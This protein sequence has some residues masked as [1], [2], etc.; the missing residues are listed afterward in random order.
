MTEKIDNALNESRILVLVT[1]VLLG[2]QY[3][4]IFQNGFEK[5]PRASQY[6]K[7]SG[8]GLMLIA[9]ALLLSPA[10]YHRIVEQGN[11]SLKFHKFISQVS[12]QALLPFAIGLSFDFYIVAD[13]LLGHTTGLLFG[14]V[15]LG[16]A[17]F[18][19]YG[20]EVLV[21]NRDPK[22]KDKPC[23]MKSQ[24][25]PLKD[26]IKFVLMEARVVLPGTQALLG[27]QFAA[28]LTESFDKLART[29]QHIHLASLDAVGLSTVCL[30]APAA[31]HRI[32]EQGEDTERLHTFSSYMVLGAMAFLALGIAGDVFVV[33]QKVLHTTSV[34]WLWSSLLWLF[35]M[36]DGLALCSFAKPGKRV[37][38]HDPYRLLDLNVQ[39]HLSQK[40]A[41]PMKLVSLSE[42]ET[43][44][45]GDGRP[46]CHR[47]DAARE[48]Q[49]VQ[50][51]CQK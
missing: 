19:W 42:L 32:V 35:S 44:D 1:Q 48:P 22:Q 37:L 8:L 33:T 6:V 27:F 46:Q 26:K 18:F 7:L 13:K 47:G 17:L 29:A 38:L 50:V 11:I 16:I 31:F 34:A 5:L 30:M 43:F 28:V 3:Q 36:V 21:A 12:E 25:T 45:S 51:R 14:V 2:F 9:L 41:S 49:Q 40:E 4:S 10:A 24:P 39:I 20:I 15:T 23:G